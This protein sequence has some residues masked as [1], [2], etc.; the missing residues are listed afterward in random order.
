MPAPRVHIVHGYTA[1]PSAHWF[2]W[3]G[4]QLAA[5][6][7]EV[8]IHAMPDS[9]QPR[10]DAW[11]AHLEREIGRP[12]DEDILLGHSLG[13]ITLL[14]Y[15]QALPE[16]LTI[17]GLILVA[18][19]DQTLPG[20]AELDPF[21][22]PHYDPDKIRRIAAQRTSIASRNDGVVPYPYSVALA[23]RL[24]SGLHSVANGGHFLG[25]EGIT[26]LPLALEHILAM[27]QRAGRVA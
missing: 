25:R 6:G 20:L 9:R 24:G 13:C 1:A 18:G 27:R 10:L 3:L 2:P 16:P 12:G 7:I 26:E 22:R 8:S 5:T 14:H 21:V 4:E 23:E 11:L 19:F 17:G 15:L